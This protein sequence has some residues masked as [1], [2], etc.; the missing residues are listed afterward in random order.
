MTGLTD[1]IIDGRVDVGNCSRRKY[2]NE[3]NI[4]SLDLKIKYRSKLQ[5]FT[6]GH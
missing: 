1:W 3:F 4:H 2:L 5:E 6:Q